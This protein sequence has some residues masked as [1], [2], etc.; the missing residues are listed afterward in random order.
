MHHGQGRWNGVAILSRV[1][2]SDVTT[3]FGDTGLVDPYEGDARLLAATCGGARIATV[4][5]PNG[6]EVDS[7]YYTRKL[8]WLARLRDWLDATASP[9]IPSRCSAT[10][11]SRP[12]T[13]TCGHPRRSPAPPT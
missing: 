9:P 10:S 6:R 12:R 5:V 7:D 8:D 1:G 2:I 4:Y 13:A 3:G 11:T